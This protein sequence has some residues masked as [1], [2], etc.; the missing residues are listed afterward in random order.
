MRTVYSLFQN[1]TV[2]KMSNVVRPHASGPFPNSPDANGLTKKT[3]CI[4]TDLDASGLISH[5][6]GSIYITYYLYTIDA[7]CASHACDLI[8]LSLA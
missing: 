1:R 8:A 2:C 6:V 4:R 7:S 5:T 3:G